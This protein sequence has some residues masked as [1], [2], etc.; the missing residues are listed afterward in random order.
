MSE[1]NYFEELEKIANEIIVDENQEPMVDDPTPEIPP[2][3]VEAIQAANGEDADAASAENQLPASPEDT[4]ALEASIL[5]AREDLEAAQEQLAEATDNFEAFEKTAAPIISES[6]PAMGAFAKL[7]EFSTNKD[8]D[9]T[10]HKLAQERLQTA[11]SSTDQFVEILHKTAQELFEDEAN[12]NALY[13]KDGMD[14]IVETLDS[15]ADADLS[16]EAFESGKVI[17]EAVDTIKDFGSATKNF[18]KLRSEVDAAKAEL[19]KAKEAYELTDVAFNQAKNT[20]ASDEVLTPLVNDLEQKS[21]AMNEADD[22]HDELL[23]QRNLGRVGWGAGGAGLAAGSLFGGKK[24]YDTVHQEPEDELSAKT[25]SDRMNPQN[26][27]NYSEGGKQ[28]MVQPYVQGILKV[29]GAAALLNISNDEKLQ[30]ELRK[31]A[32]EQFNHIS[33]LNRSE[34]D[35]S[36]VK[37]ATE[38]YTEDQLHEI[39]GGKHTEELFDKVAWFIAANE[40]SADELEKVAGADGVAAK[41]VGGALTDAKKEVE[42]HIEEEKKKS[43]TG[44]L[45]PG[46]TKAQDTAGYNVVNNPAKYDVDKTAHLLEQAHIQKEAAIS[47]Y[48]QAE[49]FISKYSKQ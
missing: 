14:Y 18:W 40:A 46:T 3:E 4:A 10:L 44:N 8:S 30:E 21:T 37:V 9:P 25:A 43:E 11:L 35:Q 15:F 29:A 22:V 48:A 12:L 24:L 31:E 39:V 2:E 32:T 38:L 20:G 34:M 49:D 5:S 13:T 23:A 41:G 16:K 7:I 6:L 47:A 17:G 26:S 33:R 36:F 45:N 28:K 27:I 19:D 42:A 1:N